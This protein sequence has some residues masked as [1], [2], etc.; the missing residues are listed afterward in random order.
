A[1]LD[2]V[3]RRF[4]ML[5]ARRQRL[6]RR[7]DGDEIDLDAYIEHRADVAAGSSGAD[8]LYELRRAA[9]RDLA[10]LLPLDVSGPTH[11]WLDVDRR[12]IDIEREALLIVSVA[13]ESLGEP[14]AIEAF[15]GEGPE[16]VTSRAVKHFDEPYG[17]DVARRIA[18]LEPER[19]TRA[20][21][22]IRHA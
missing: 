12:I 20:G 9:D 16:H 5:Q 3:R 6:R 22:A 13:L 18:G 21:A 7:T 1:M 4:E 10:V 19:Y 2:A 11:G 15:S 8:G 14:F 17:R